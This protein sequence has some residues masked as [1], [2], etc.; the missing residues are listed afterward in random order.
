MLDS[1]KTSVGVGRYH[2]SLQPIVLA[3]WSI[4]IILI[5]QEESIP[6]ITVNVMIHI[7]FPS[8]VL[9]TQTQ[10]LGGSCA[11]DEIA[12]MEQVI[13]SIHPHYMKQQLKQN[14]EIPRS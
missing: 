4:L 9:Y 10:E 5:K 11:T 3:T 1:L 12:Q 13:N 2:K 14:K 6:I 8:N 7:A